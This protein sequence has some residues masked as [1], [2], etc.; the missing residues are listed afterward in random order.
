M[1]EGLNEDVGGLRKRIDNCV[2]LNNWRE[3]LKVVK[4]RKRKKV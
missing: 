4:R 1:E 2:L 3:D